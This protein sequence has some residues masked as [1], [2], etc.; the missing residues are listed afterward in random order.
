[1]YEPMILIVLTY[2]IEIIYSQSKLNL[3]KLNVVDIYGV[4]N[5]KMP[6]RNLLDE[7]QTAGDPL[8]NNNAKPCI[9]PWIPSMY[10]EYYPIEY[11]EYPGPAA[12]IDLQSLFEITNIC[13]YI[14]NNNASNWLDFIIT[15]N[16][17]KTNPF[18]DPTLS[19]TTNIT[20]KKYAN[21]WNCFNITNIIS[22]FITVSL[23]NPPSTSFTEIVVYGLYSQP[24]YIPPHKFTN[25]FKVPRKPLKSLMG[26]SGFGYTPVENFTNTVGAVRQWQMW[27]WIEG[28]NNHNYPGYPNNQNR[29]QCTAQATYCQDDVL[30]AQRKNNV[31]V[32]A[33][34]WHVPG[35]VHNWNE[36]ENDW[37]PIADNILHQPGASVDPKNWIMF[38]DHM[39]QG[40]TIWSSK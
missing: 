10:A 20:R 34:V 30:L 26:S 22:G 29:Y 16:F 2:F 8:N 21:H 4:Y 40:S 19:I 25:T 23:Y 13:I 24:Q 15:W 1:M 36:T 6:V 28:N 27:P 5:T 9:T 32:H 7:Q 38:A 39:F 18:E 12:V 31:S 35:W 3:S 11:P 33:C 14:A 17:T 37:K